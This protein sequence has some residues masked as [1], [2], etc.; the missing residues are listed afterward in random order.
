MEL[1]LKSHPETGGGGSIPKDKVEDLGGDA[2]V[3]SLDDSEVILDPL[4]IMG[5]RHGGGVE[6]ERRLQRPR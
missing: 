5:L 3:D 6:W 2:H 1:L 4:E